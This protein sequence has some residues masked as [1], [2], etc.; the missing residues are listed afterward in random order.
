MHRS[1]LAVI[2]VASVTALVLAAEPQGNS[3]QN[4]PPPP[5]QQQRPTELTLTLDN[6][7]S[8]PRIGFQPLALSDTRADVR[9]AAETILDVLAADLDF[10][11]E[12]YVI[13]RKASAGVPIAPTPQTLPF[14]RWTELGADFVAMGSLRETAGTLTVDI[15]LIN[16]RGADAG[17][18]DF[19][20]SYSGCTLANPRYCAH[21]I[22]D[23]IHKQKRNLDGVA[24]TRI[25][26]TSDR[27]GEAAIGRPIP[28]AGP[29]KEIY[30]M[31]YD[32]E[33]ER[34]L[35]TNRNLNIGANWGPDGRMLAYASY[36]PGAPPDI[37][38]TLLDGRPATRPAHGP[39]STA[40]HSP[41]ISPDGTK[42]AFT[43]NQGGQT[44][45][46]DVWVVNRDGS[47]LRNL[48]PNTPRSSEGAPTWSPNGAQIAFTSDRTGTNQV[49]IMNAD[50][51]GVRRITFAEKCDRPTWSALNFIAYTLER[52]GGKDIAV[53]DLSRMEARV[54]TDGLGSNEQPT[55]SPNGRHI[56]FVTSRW[57]KRQIAVIDF[58]DGKNYRQLTTLGNNTYPSWSPLPGAR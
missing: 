57:G 3:R 13:S 52:P 54:L 27:D 36:L 18:Q 32:G 56:A 41:A 12:F 20:Q 47:G 34:R 49:F 58:P 21:A 5:P 33:N 40:N 39:E 53:T 4:P 30:L 37:F 51:T 29:G 10:E 14:A 16:V 38:V 42:I 26:F 1:I 55:V 28:D 17:R 45:Y 50:G 6:P 22:A 25:A 7:G 11:K 48:T 35:T 23:D 24:R 46:V 44:G 2:G 15:R 19:G 43:S 8:H 9:T 31:D